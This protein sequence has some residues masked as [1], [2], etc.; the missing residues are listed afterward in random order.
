MKN[1]LEWDYDEMEEMECKPGWR[2]GRRREA[3][4]RGEGGRRTAAVAEKV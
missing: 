4:R 2:E 1:N 3:R